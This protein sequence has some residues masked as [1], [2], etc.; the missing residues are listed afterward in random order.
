MVVSIFVNVCQSENVLKTIKV[1]ED[2]KNGHQVLSFDNAT[3]DFPVDGNIHLEDI[4][5]HRYTLS[6]VVGSFCYFIPA[7]L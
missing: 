5:Q 7:I 3:H 6:S 1:F 4:G 2:Q